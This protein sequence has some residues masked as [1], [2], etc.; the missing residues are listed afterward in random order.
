MVTDLVVGVDVGGGGSQGGQE[1]AEA[2]NACEKPEPENLGTESISILATNRAVRPLAGHYIFLDI[3]SPFIKQGG[4][5][6]L[7]VGTLQLNI[8]VCICDTQWR[9]L[10][11]LV[12]HVPE[13]K[14]KQPQIRHV[15]NSTAKC[16]DRKG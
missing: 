1:K 14:S 8:Y 12:S 10:G 13:S 16:I 5:D 2:E 9:T 6:L 3:E 4:W 7:P 15:R 11:L